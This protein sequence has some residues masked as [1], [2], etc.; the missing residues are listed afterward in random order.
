M[1]F[2]DGLKLEVAQF[3]SAGVKPINEDSIGIR[4]PDD[5]QLATKGAVVV[6]ADGVSAAEAGKEAAESCVTGFLNDYYS[7][8]DTWSVKRSGQQVL[9]ALNRW[10]YAQGQSFNA[11]EKGYVSTLSVA[12]F[13]SRTLHIFHVGDTR[14]YRWR[15][16]ALEQLTRDH[17]RQIGRNQT[18][19]TRAMGLDISLDVDYRALDVEFG[20]LYLLSS[21]GVHDVLSTA[22]IE[23]Y[24]Q[25]GISLSELS[26]SL[27]EAA[28]AGGSTDNLSCQVVSV[29]GMPLENTDEVYRR[30]T[31]LPFPPALAVGDVIDGLLVEEEIHA[32]TR[33]QLYRVYDAGADQRYVMKTPSENFC[34]DPAYIERFILESWIGRRIDHA[35]VVKIIDGSQRPHFL[36]YL[37]EYLEGSTL[38]AWLA[39]RD[40]SINEVMA[41]IEEIG[42]A[43]QSMHRRDTL[44]QDIKPDN[45]MVLA[46]GSIKLIDFGSCYVAGVAEMATPIER[47][48]VLGTAHYS[49]PEHVLGRKPGVR[50]DQFSLAVITYEMLT[51]KHPYEGKLES[52]RSS[53]AFNRLHYVS[54]C[55]LNSLV[56]VWMDKALQKALSI[57]PELRYNDIAEFVHDLKYPNPEFSQA[58]YQPLIRRNPLRFWQA[59]SFLLAVALFWSLSR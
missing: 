23:G 7:T 44:H 55:K 35:G 32:S 20:D 15:D 56:P 59:V 12:V 26:Q 13:K 21:D 11:A 41:K 50:A 24:L 46:D 2:D 4:V 29:K 38:G 22:E 18:Y 33:S 31:E 16:G 54:A 6:I 57:S 39:Q 52:C 34:D 25:R 1:Y 47:D 48:V 45:I 3:S 27:V 53:T 42:K 51:G 28:E 58:E 19:L 5:H 8:P 40:V 14:V 37:S 10:L 9:N 43:I 30:L 49:A 17:A 36:Y